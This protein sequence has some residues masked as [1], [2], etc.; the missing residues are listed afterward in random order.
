MYFNSGNFRPN[1]NFMIVFINKLD[2]AAISNVE[3]RELILESFY[4][5]LAETQTEE[6]E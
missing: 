3:E 5:I 6:Q 2:N 4:K 1:P